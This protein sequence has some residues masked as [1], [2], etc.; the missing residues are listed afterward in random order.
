MPEKLALYAAQKPAIEFR[1][2]CIKFWKGVAKL[3]Q[4]ILAKAMTIS[5]IRFAAPKL[6]V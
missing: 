5:M 3:A 4:F 6:A 1:I 2:L